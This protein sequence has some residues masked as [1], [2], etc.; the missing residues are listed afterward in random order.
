MGGAVQSFEPAVF[1]GEMRLPLQCNRAPSRVST[2][3]DWPPHPAHGGK[4]LVLSRTWSPL[5][6]IRDHLPDDGVLDACAER[7]LDRGPL[8]DRPQLSA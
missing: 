3:R 7:D 8:V 6:G 4:A 1:A 5:R 2:E